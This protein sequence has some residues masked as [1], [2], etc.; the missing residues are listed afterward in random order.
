MKWYVIIM[1]PKVNF[2]R[3]EFLYHTIIIIDMVEYLNRDLLYII[4]DDMHAIITNK[5]FK[6]IYIY[7]G[8]PSSFIV[9]SYII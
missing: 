9:Y 1:I 8:L 7:D 2:I 3:L 4:F 5:P 6:I